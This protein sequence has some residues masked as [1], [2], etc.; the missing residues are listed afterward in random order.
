VSKTKPF[1]ISKKEVMAAWE[2]AKL[3]KG[4]YGVDQE[5]IEDF[6]LN[7]KDNLY[8]L[9]N[10][11]SSGTYFP[12]AVRAVEIPKSDGRK[13]LLG[14]PT[15]K[16]RI[17]QGVVKSY[18]E[19]IVEPKFEENSYGYRPGRSALETVRVARERYWRQSWCIDLDIKGFFDKIDHGL[20]MKVVK[21]YA[22]EKWIHL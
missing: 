15:V 1:S 14:T 6:E 12:P 4:A 19:A 13:R 8:K 16:D 10:R 3:N 20:M 18:L 11:L 5:S 21:F 7:L 9:W 22:K 2:R 17:A